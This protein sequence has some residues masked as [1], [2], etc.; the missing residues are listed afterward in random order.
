MVTNLPLSL[1]FMDLVKSV[2]AYGTVQEP[3]KEGY[4]VKCNFGCVTV[5]TNPVY[6]RIS[7][8]KV[9]INPSK[10]GMS[11]AQ[12]GLWIDFMFGSGNRNDVRVKRV[13]LKIDLF[14]I[15]YEAL[16]DMLW[17]GGKYRS[18]NDSWD[19]TLYLGSRRRDQWRIYD[20]GKESGQQ[21]D[22]SRIEYVHHFKED[23][24]FG[25]DELGTYLHKVE[26]FQRAMLID[27]SPDFVAALLN[28]YG[29]SPKD[30]Q[31]QT[32]KQLRYGRRKT[33][34]TKLM[35]Y[36]HVTQLHESYEEQLLDWLNH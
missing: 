30:T 5:W 22:V 8:T 21:G 27:T 35:Q 26:F 31:I 7:A 23:E 18:V 28:K 20:K 12:M 6:P 15:P 4:L 32:L 25:I 14:G 13:E 9:R 36:G 10:A 11:L 19:T 1:D 34:L 17:V 29:M 2:R 3:L 24:R 33:V 16:E